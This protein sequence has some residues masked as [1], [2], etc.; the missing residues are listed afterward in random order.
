VTN[1]TDREI[2]ASYAE[3]RIGVYFFLESQA[4]A[5]LMELAA[6]AGLVDARLERFDDGTEL[7][8]GRWDSITSVF[9][10]VSRLSFHHCLELYGSL[11]SF[12]ELRQR[13]GDN[14]ELERDGA[15]PVALA[16]RDACERLEP[17]AACLEVH[18]GRTNLEW[19]LEEIYPEVLGWS[20]NALGGAHLSLL[21]MGERMAGHWQPNEYLA[22]RD[23]LPVE[24]GLLLFA[25]RGAKRWS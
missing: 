5:S 25:R 6:N 13:S 3:K 24:N 4:P 20:A 21:Y 17:E 11:L 10:R 9:G 22:D 23:S 14:E 12:H 2:Y 16:F 1:Q 19:I 18:V 8:L 15:L 7:A